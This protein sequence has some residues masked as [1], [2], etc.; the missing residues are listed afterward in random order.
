[1]A[2]VLSG[3][4]GRFNKS[5][6]DALRFLCLGS[7]DIA[8]EFLITGLCSAEDRKS[9][10]IKLSTLLDLSSLAQEANT[11]LPGLLCCGSIPSGYSFS[12]HRETIKQSRKG[13]VFPVVHFPSDESQRCAGQR[14]SP[15]KHAAN[16]KTSSI[17]RHN[18]SLSSL[19][20]WF[21]PYMIHD[22][23]SVFSVQP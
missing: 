10:N 9:K 19:K 14:N 1:M 3:S 18:L 23:F 11:A 20:K 12:C 16:L 17:I 5:S 22:A 7:W 2:L 6:E 15:Q 21:E 13:I 4:W 8:M